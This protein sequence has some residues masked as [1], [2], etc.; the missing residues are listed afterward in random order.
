MDIGRDGYGKLGNNKQK[1]KLS[2]NEGVQ[3]KQGQGEDKNRGEGRG[4]ENGEYKNQGGKGKERIK[5]AERW[6]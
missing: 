3:E 2:E 5:E 1:G 4:R 6:L